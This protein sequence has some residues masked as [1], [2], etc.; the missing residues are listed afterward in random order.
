MVAWDS[1]VDSFSSSF[2]SSRFSLF[3]Q[4]RG[5]G[6]REEEGGVKKWSEGL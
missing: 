6:Q 2:E 1:L 4:G 5:R 3:V